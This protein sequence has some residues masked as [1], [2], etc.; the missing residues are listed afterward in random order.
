ML[1]QV[2]KLLNVDL[3]QRVLRAE[4]VDLVVN[5]VID[6]R[7][8][9]VSRVVLHGLP[10]QLFLQPVYNLD[11]LEVDSNS[12]LCTARHISHGIC[13]HR[14][15]HSV[16]ASDHGKLGMPAGLHGALKQGASTEINPDVAFGDLV[17]AIEDN[18][19]HKEHHTDYHF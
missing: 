12:T 9:V 11:L 8:V 13:L 15:L 1:I 16:V 2:V 4:L 7:L 5:L 10:S 19:A 3:M 18:C 17:D 14:Y 6:P